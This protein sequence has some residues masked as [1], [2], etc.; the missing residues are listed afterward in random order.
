MTKTSPAVAVWPAFS[1]L[2]YYI[3]VFFIMLEILKKIGLFPE[4]GKSK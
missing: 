4:K 1:S 2:I 3:I